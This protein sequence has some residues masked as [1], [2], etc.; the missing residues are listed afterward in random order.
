MPPAAGSWADSLPLVQ[1]LL[2]AAR[3]WSSGTPVDFEAVAAVRSEMLAANHRRHV[4]NIPAYGEMAREAG[5]GSGADI[6]ELRERL[7]LSDEWFKSYDPAWM[8]G[9]LPAL[10]SW[11]ETVS[12]VRLPPPPPAAID[13][14]TWRESLKERGVFVTISSGTTGLPA[15]VPRDRLTLA[16]LRSSSGVRLPWSL[17][18][19]DYDSLLLT[20]V[21][22]GSGL[23][24]GAAGLAASS[25]RIHHYQGA[26]WLEFL[27][28]TARQQQKA[29][30]Y[31]PPARLALLEEELIQDGKQIDLPEGSCVLTG[32]GWK[33][34][35]VH[36]IGGLLDR[37]SELFGVARTRCI[38]TYATAE[39][40]TVF[41][42]CAEGR[43]HVP[44]VVE[45]LVVDDL[46]RPLPGEGD[47]RLAVLDPM[48]I[49][50][51]G[52]LATSDYARLRNDSCPC[53]LDGQ[54]L[55]YPVTRLPDAAP[56]GC[57][58]TDPVA[59]G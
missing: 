56:R 58:V 55:L 38:D 48:A 26:G 43:Y 57:G 44:P 52:R 29:I 20:P 3:M 32:G 30:I 1:R 5:L 18:P 28:E 4:T 39:L 42:S 16:A 45:A 54:T 7:M 37:A 47:G 41:A 8:S 46:L 2:V 17:P 14:A 24:A 50:Y 15:L 13:L 35:P 59:S 22:M 10:S 49:S 40:N 31:G 23:Q 27:C 9:N 36:D 19:G 11:L 6:G 51:P 25:R 33:Q 53:G 21:G 12:T 34:K